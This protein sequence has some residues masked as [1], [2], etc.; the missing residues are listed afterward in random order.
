M[1][2]KKPD[3]LVFLA[4]GGAGEI[5]MNLDLYGLGTPGGETWVMVDLGITFEIGRAHV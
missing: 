3:E 4:L 1:N 5:G 2:P